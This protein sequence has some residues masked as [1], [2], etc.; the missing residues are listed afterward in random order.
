MKHYGVYCLMHGGTIKVFVWSYG[1]M[2]RAFFFSFSLVF[3]RSFYVSFYL[4]IC[5]TLK[6]RTQANL[7]TKRQQLPATPKATAKRKGRATMKTALAAT[8]LAAT[9]VAAAVAAAAVVVLRRVPR[10]IRWWQCRCRRALATTCWTTSTT[11]TRFDYR[12]NNN[13][14]YFLL[15]LG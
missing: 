13:F 15:L 4:L 8:A 10:G 5:R 2:L 9:A 14:P 7:S 12:F 1:R 3:L 11:T 6:V